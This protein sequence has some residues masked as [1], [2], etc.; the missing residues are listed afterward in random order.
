MHELGN[1]SFDADAFWASAGIGC[2]IVILLE[3]QTFFSRGVA[4]DFIFY[5]ESGRAKLTDASKNGKEAAI[6]LF[7]AGDFVGKE[8]LAPER[9]DWLRWNTRN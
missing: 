3:N 5:L 7:S 2:R 9:R 1:P 6:T 4:A 8:L